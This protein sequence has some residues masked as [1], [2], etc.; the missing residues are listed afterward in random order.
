MILTSPLI[1]EFVKHVSLASCSNQDTSVR[2][3]NQLFTSLCRSSAEG[4]PGWPADFQLNCLKRVLSAYGTDGKGAKVRAKVLAIVIE[5]LQ[6]LQ[7]TCSHKTG[8]PG[9]RGQVGGE[10]RR[11]HVI[12]M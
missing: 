5:M 2:V 11:I 8:R 1:F 7:D 12:V 6:A 4:G 9:C 3:G 10:Q